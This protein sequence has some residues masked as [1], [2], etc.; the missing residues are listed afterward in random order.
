VGAAVSSVPPDASVDVVDFRATVNVPEADLFVIYAAPDATLGVE[1]APFLQSRGAGAPAILV[2]AD[3]L[4]L[5][6]SLGDCWIV[7]PGSLA[8]AL[9]NALAMPTARAAEVGGLPG[10]S[11]C[12]GV[13]RTCDG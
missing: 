13:C 6:A 4:E 5:P 7:A 9:P 11:R 3:G 2:G 8:V 12:T 1:Q 10:L